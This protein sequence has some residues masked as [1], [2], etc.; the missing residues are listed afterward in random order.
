M[1]KR[2]FV[3][4]IVA[5]GLGALA[6]YLYDW[7]CW[8][9]HLRYIALHWLGPLIGADGEKGYDA[10]LYES[11]IDFGVVF[12]LVFLAVRALVLWGKRPK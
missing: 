7:L 6:G 12:A 1:T 11:M 3:C 4:L 10:L 8:E 5:F 9:Y 2:L